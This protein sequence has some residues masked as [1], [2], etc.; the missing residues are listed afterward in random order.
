[1]AGP[2][3]KLLADLPEGSWNEEMKAICGLEDPYAQ[4]WLDAAWQNPRDGLKT[5]RKKG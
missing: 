1:M 4:I 2:G 3:C 5:Q